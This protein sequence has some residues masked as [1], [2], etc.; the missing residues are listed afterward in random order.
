MGKIRVLVVDDSALVR[1]ILSR[2]LSQDPGIE[3]VGTATDPYMAR[4][5]ILQLHPDVLTLDVEMPRM[6]GV[7]FLRR[8]MAQYPLP[9]I[10][11][12]AL[13]ERGGQITMEA[14]EAG[15][16][17][18]VNKPK[19]DIARGLSAMMQELRAKV[20]MAAAA[21]LDAWKRLAQQKKQLPAQRP[22]SG[23][24]ERAL[25]N[26]T[27]KVIAIGASTGGT[28]AIRRIVKML[29]PTMPGVVIVQHMPAGFTKSFA[30]S[31]NDVALMEVMEAQGGERVMPGRVLLAPGGKHM[32]VRRSG[33]MYLVECYEGPNV[34]GH[35]PSVDVLFKSV[36]QQ[37]GRNALGVILTGMGSDGADGM[38]EMRRA[39]GRT[40]AQNEASSVVFGM[41]RAAYE[42]GGAECL[43]SLGDIP[44]TLLKWLR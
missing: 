43:V 17:D 9:V 2:G 11:V 42:N 1:D 31:L 32:R 21:N 29:P 10:M 25:A 30:S 44:D 4:D 16:I 41:P 40:L 24:E 5:K 26:S 37:V 12:S 39:G 14:L 7:A 19:A 28:E 3:V 36:S 6:D 18:F 23:Q 38:A 34:S 22:V 33:G 27:D 35:C 20:K 13:T 15:A 8:L